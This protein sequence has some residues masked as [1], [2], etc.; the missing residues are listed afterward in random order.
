MRRDHIE[1]GHFALAIIAVALGL[2]AVAVILI[3]E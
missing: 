3:G 2:A 1:A